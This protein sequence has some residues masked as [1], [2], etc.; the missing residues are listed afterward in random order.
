MVART[1]F[2]SHFPEQSPHF[3][4]LNIDDVRFAGGIQGLVPLVEV[5]GV[6]ESSGSA[7][8]GS[9]T[10]VNMPEDMYLSVSSLQRL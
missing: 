5:C 6:H 9:G 2:G 7:R 3:D 4:M 8:N 10:A 1:A